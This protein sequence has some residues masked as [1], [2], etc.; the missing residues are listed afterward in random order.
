MTS[1][2]TKAL[3]AFHADVGAI[4]KS[5]KAQYGLFADLSTVL[6]TVIP[7]LVKNGLVITQTF[8]PS[9]VGAES[10]LVTTLRHVSGETIE[11]VLPLVVNQGRNKLHDLGA[12]VTYLRRYALLSLVGLVADVDTDGA[13]TED[14]PQPKAAPTQK[15]VGKKTV[16][17]KTAPKPEPA[18]QPEQVDQ[19]LSQTDR[20]LLMALLKE[21]HSQNAT[22]IQELSKAFKKA[23][24][25]TADSPLSQALRTTAHAEFINQYFLDNG[26]PG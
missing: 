12:S 6:S 1:E 3:C 25:D 22:Q 14:E 9:E 26:N 20:E 15:P 13:F 7:P 4:H 19:P 11:S 16:A 23:F 17:K 24:P 8:Q 21:R 18:V 5:A 2:L 10:Y